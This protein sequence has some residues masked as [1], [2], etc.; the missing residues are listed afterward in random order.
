MET[1]DG[2]HAIIRKCLPT[3]QV[4]EK[5]GEGVHGN[6][7]R[8]RDAFKERAVKVVCIAV[9]GSSACRSPVELDARI[10]QD[11]HA[12]RDYYESIKG[13][14]VVEIHDFHMVDKQVSPHDAQGY[15]VILMEFCPR[16][17]QGHVLDRHPLPPQQALD[18]A[19]EL[20]GVLDRLSRGGG[21]TFLMTDLKPSNLLITRHGRLVIGDLGGLKRIATVSTTSSAQSK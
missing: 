8:V 15:L 14:G 4:V 2:M 5:I 6:V 7:Y 17:L 20:A 11:F 9:E 18:M 13:P 10:S 3:Y 1:R 19:R 12:V 21:D 16:S